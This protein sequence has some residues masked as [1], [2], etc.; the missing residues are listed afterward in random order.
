MAVRVLLRICVGFAVG[1][2][3]MTTARAEGPT[4][5]DAPRSDDFVEQRQIRGQGGQQLRR[6]LVDKPPSSSD[7]QGPCARDRYLKVTLVPEFGGRI[8]SIIYKPTGHEELYRTEVGVPYGRRA[9][10][11]YDWLMVY[12]GIFPTFRMPSTAGPG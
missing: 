6:R 8:I 5:S 9:A 10:V 11:L 12:G 2:F 3:F 7:L 1:A 4:E